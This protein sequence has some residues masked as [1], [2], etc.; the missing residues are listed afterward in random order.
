MK[1][2]ITIILIVI[3]LLVIILKSGL[4]A[5]QSTLLEEQMY[6]EIE[7]DKFTNNN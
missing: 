6:D 3:I 2:L 4:K 5:R 7:K 1:I